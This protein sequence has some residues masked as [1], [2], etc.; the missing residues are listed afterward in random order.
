MGIFCWLWWIPRLLSRPSEKSGD[1]DCAEE[2]KAK[3]SHYEGESDEPHP[4]YGQQ[5][6]AS[7]FISSPCAKAV[8]LS[9][10]EGAIMHIVVRSDADPTFSFE[11]SDGH[12]PIA[13]PLPPR[14]VPPFGEPFHH[15]SPGPVPVALPSYPLV[16]PHS[17]FNV[18]RLIK[19]CRRYVPFPS[20]LRGWTRPPP[21]MPGVLPPAPFFG[22]PKNPRFILPPGAKTDFKLAVRQQPERAKPSCGKTERRPLDPPAVLELLKQNGPISPAELPKLVVRCTLWDEEGREHRSILK[23]APIASGRES[24]QKARGRADEGDALALE[25]NIY[26]T[27]Q[28]LEDDHGKPGYFY[29]FHDLSIKIKGNFRLKFDLLQGVAPTLFT[30]AVAAECFSD[31]FVSY[32]A[33]RFPGMMQSTKLTKAF[34]R[35]GLNIKV[36]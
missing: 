14:C 12:R 1:S 28:F 36:R 35:Q 26:Q 25:G 4:E 5:H 29:I 11:T 24:G 27:G 7:M 6:S 22:P 31:T 18:A 20:A 21:D 33:E 3:I 15:S 32:A 10:Y 23:A 30:E 8:D 13:P 17:D 34:A 16:P 19:V 2:L 9:P